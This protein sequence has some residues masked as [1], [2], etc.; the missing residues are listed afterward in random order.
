MLSSRVHPR[1]PTARL[2]VER[3]LLE[4]DA[5][6]LALDLGEAAGLLVG[7]GID[8]AE[9]DVGELV[10]RTEGRPA[11]LY[12]AVRDARRRS[13]PRAGCC[14]QWQQPLP[15]GLPASR[16]P[17]PVG[18]VRGR[19]PDADRDPREHDWIVVRRGPRHPRIGGP[20]R[21][22][23]SPERAGRAAGRSARADRY[24]RL[25]RE[26]L[27]DELHRREPEVVLELHARAAAWY[28]SNGRP[29]LAL[30]HVQAA[31]DVDR[32]AI[33]LLELVQP[34]WASGRA[35]TALRW[36]EWLADEDLLDRYPALA[37][38]ARRP[39]VRVGYPAQA[40][41][42]SAAAVVLVLLDLPDGSSMESLLDAYLRAFVCRDGVAAMRSDAVSS[43][44]GLSP[45]SPYRASMLFTQGL[46]LLIED[47]PEQAQPVLVRS[48]DAAVAIGA[49]PMAAMVFAG[50]GPG[51]GPP[52][53]LGRRDPRR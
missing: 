28:Q 31:K 23:R 50:P 21:G 10:D 45:S 46:V 39:H 49:V 17:R 42:W 6:D 18:T 40:D 41:T 34:V 12:L 13:R 9:V 38:R 7:A 51:R 22:D 11:G 26:L 36:L 33:L 48:A 14:T 30:Q 24:H 8:P 44:E 5:Q 20:A 47:D 35:R 15:R 3:R 52:R 53:R 27:H 29:E 25:F 43:Y 16:D 37:R 2:R 19:V 4:I 1:L 32:A